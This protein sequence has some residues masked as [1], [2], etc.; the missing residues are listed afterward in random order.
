LSSDMRYSKIRF[1]LSRYAGQSSFV[2][3]EFLFGI[4]I[5]SKGEADLLKLNP[6]LSIDSL[7]SIKKLVATSMLRANRLGHINRCIG[8]VI[9][10]E[11]LLDKV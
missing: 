3:V 6:F 5:S 8:L 4:L 9:S 11:N 7:D 10:L 2:W 1:L